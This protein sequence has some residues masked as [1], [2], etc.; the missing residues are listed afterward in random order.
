[1][2]F[3][4]ANMG[5]AYLKCGVQG[6]AGSGK[7]F[8]GTMIAIGLHQYIHS[9]KPITFLDSETGSDY[10]QNHFKSAGIDLMV[11]KTRAFVDLL[12]AIDEAEKTSDILVIDSITHFWNELVEAYGKKRGK[13]RLTLKDWSEIKPEWHQFTNRYLNSRL[14]IL[15]LGRAGWD[16]SQEEDEEGVKELT[17]TGTKMKVETD[18]GYEPSLSIE[19]ERVHANGK[20]GS[21]FDYRGWILKDRFNIINGEFQSFKPSK[22]DKLI[23]GIENPVFKFVLPH[24]RALNLGGEQS[25]IDSNGKTGELFNTDR[26]M[27]EMFKKREIALEE[28]EDQITLLYP[29]RDAESNK[30]KI[31]LLKNLFGTSAWTGIKSMP[32]EKILEAQKKLMEKET[33]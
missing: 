32:L 6:F 25:T 28:I 4:P 11:G 14:H 5:S 1:M 22:D 24:I 27:A 7:S 12:E 2:I 10:L 23:L 20:I 19:M 15:M 16:W 30:A 13:K 3:K 26:S 17:K 8:S 31:N 18:L 21:S 29:G 9:A 33:V